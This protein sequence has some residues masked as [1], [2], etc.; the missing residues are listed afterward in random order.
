MSQNNAAAA[1]TEDV[2]DSWAVI[3][4][5]KGLT[6]DLHT[7]VHKHT[8]INSHENLIKYYGN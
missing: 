2:D 8:Q 3:P 5:D 6:S 4:R 1:A 7:Y